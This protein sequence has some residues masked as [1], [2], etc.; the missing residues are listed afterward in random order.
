MWF[1]IKTIVGPISIIILIWFVK[2]VKSLSRDP[3][4]LEK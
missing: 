2:R 1:T 4:L 3:M